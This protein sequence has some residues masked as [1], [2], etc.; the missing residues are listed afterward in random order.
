M[1][2]NIGPKCRLC[3]REG[4]KLYLKGKRCD[5]AKCAFE[6]QNTRA[7][8]PGQHGKLRMRA[9]LSTF[10][11]G[12]REKQK[13]KRIY[14]IFEKQFKMYFTEASPQKGNTADLLI[15]IIERRL[16]NVIY[17]L[18]FAKSRSH[19]RQLIAHGHIFLNGKRVDIASYLVKAGELITLRKK[20][21]LEP[22]K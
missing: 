7:Y 13:F 6:G 14:G 12:M 15:L 16:D 18:G 2:R 22:L 5:S 3:R 10:G 21:K 20:E 1:A 9:K 19:A 11:R 17:Q 8:P 4:I